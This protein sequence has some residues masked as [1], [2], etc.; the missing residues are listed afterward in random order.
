M[1]ASVSTSD[2][3][4]LTGHY[5]AGAWLSLLHF[6]GSFFM[7]ECVFYKYFLQVATEA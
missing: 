3:L 7:C 4:K 6:P 5:S 1:D 2:V